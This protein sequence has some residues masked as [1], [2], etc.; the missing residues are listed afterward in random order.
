MVVYLMAYKEKNH[1]CCCMLF[2]SVSSNTAV[3]ICSVDYVCNN[4][5]VSE[6]N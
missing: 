6:I 3:Y 1:L 4:S 2:R 5:I